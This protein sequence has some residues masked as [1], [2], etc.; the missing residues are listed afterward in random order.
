M[1]WP[2]AIEK[3]PLAG[4]GTIIC[5]SEELAVYYGEAGERAAVIRE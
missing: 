4:F 2:Q 1:T 5:I 3:V